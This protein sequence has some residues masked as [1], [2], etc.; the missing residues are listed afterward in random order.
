[1]LNLT[2]T[3]LY[4]RECDEA[5]ARQRCWG[6]IYRVIIINDDGRESE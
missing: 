6:Q 1:M 4:P 2:R 5:R 3:G